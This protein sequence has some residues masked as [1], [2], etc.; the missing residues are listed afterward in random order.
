MQ[1]DNE[2]TSVSK[3]KFWSSS[4]GPHITERDN[5]K[6]SYEIFGDPSSQ[7]NVEQKE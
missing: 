4:Y 1:L 6:N 5:S 3:T 7:I 2:T